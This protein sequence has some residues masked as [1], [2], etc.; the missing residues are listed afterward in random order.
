MLRWLCYC[1]ECDDFEII[2]EEEGSLDW[3]LEPLFCPFCS[4][5]IEIYEED[6]EIE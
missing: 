4:G 2:K 1:E 3:D 5:Q 6:D